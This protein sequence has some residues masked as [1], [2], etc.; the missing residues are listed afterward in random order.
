MFKSQ[1]NWTGFSA[2]IFEETVFLLLF[3]RVDCVNTGAW[4]IR[5]TK[6][7]EHKIH[8]PTYRIAATHNRRPI[9]CFNTHEYAT[10]DLTH[11][12]SHSVD[13]CS[14]V[15][16]YG[17]EQ[18]FGLRLVRHILAEWSSYKAR[19]QNGI[20]FAL[21]QSSHMYTKALDEPGGSVRAEEE[22]GQVSRHIRSPSFLTF[23]LWVSNNWRGSL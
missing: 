4:I 7:K 23:D 6:S 21:R 9:L 12:A 2:V 16:E 11:T 22:G 3:F 5:D 14:E 20:S 19:Q 17:L 1:E 13:G 18:L 15:G 10:R 8:R